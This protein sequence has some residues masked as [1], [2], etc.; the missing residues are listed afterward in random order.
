VN[1][2]IFSICTIFPHAH[3][4]DRYYYPKNQIPALLYTFS[5]DPMS[6][7]DENLFLYSYTSEATVVYKDNPTPSTSTATEDM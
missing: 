6:T 7:R 3:H 4:F 5:K 1:S 2:T